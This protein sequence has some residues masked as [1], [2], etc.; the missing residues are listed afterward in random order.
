[1]S[2]QT[3]TISDTAAAHVLAHYGHEGGYQA[4]TFTQNLITAFDTA[5]PGNFARLAEAFPEYG[6][7]I[8]GMKYDPDGASVLQR[9]ARGGETA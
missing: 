1:M 8:V 5:D 3:P 6:A 9:I 4:G 2:Q 7:A